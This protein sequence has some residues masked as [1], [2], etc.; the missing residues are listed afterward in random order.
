MQKGQEDMEQV[1]KSLH[2]KERASAWLKGWAEESDMMD[3]WRMKHPQGQEFTWVHKQKQSQEVSKM[4]AEL[5][6]QKEEEQEPE[7][8]TR[9]AELEELLDDTE[10]E[11]TEG[12]KIRKVR[13]GRIDYIN[14]N[15]KSANICTNAK[16]CPE[17]EESHGQQTTKQSA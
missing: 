17:E 7:N 14:M 8:D 2:Q 11:Q 5:E 4:L 1:T 9:R 13:E 3:I 10:E 12:K 16:I 6:G 15:A